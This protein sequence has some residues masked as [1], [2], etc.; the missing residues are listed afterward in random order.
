MPDQLAR[1]QRQRV[2]LPHA[3]QQLP[4]RPGVGEA[5]RADA[6]RPAKALRGALRHDAEADA[7]RDHPADAVEGPHAGAERQRLP[8]QQRLR[9]D[10]RLHRAALAEADE[11]VL[12][13][14][15]KRDA[16]LRGQGMR[17]RNR[18]DEAV[19]GE[20]KGLQRAVR[21]R[22]RND[23]DV[24]EAAGDRLHGFCA[25][26]LLDVHA[27]QRPPG[28][29]DAE[30]VRQELGQRDG[31]GPQA[32]VRLDARRVLAQLALH[33]L[34]LLQHQARVMGQ[35]VAGRRR[36]DAAPAAFEQGQADGLFH[37]ADAGARRRQRKI[38]LRRA[39][40][41]APR[42]ED[43]QEKAEVGQIEAHGGNL[44]SRPAFGKG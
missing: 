22:V 29:E 7:V 38:G 15:L 41:D 39:V 1:R 34:D 3:E 35:R 8:G 43:A 17:A 18:E 14:L 5:D 36:F 28:E 42:F 24:G 2:E 40:R 32:D 25:Q 21:H 13:D 4:R 26:A 9:I 20:G 27:D 33:L 44:S 23:A 19:G 16:P 6:R 10:M 37:A 31:V 30:H 12:H 11:I